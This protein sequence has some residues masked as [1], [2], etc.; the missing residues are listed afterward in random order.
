MSQRIEM[1]TEMRTD[2]VKFDRALG[3]SDRLATAI[4]PGQDP[5]QN[6]VEMRDAGGECDRETQFLFRLPNVRGL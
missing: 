3:C 2:A 6:I 4:L 5:A 1:G